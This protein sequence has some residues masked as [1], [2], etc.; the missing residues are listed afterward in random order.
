MGFIDWQTALQQGRL[1]VIQSTV[2]YQLISCDIIQS[3]MQVMCTQLH[4]L[5]TYVPCVHDLNS[6]APGPR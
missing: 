5:L 1:D 3:L 2:P 4:W 6:A